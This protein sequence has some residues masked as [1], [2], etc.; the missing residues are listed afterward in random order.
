MALGRLH[1]G[2]GYRRPSAIDPRAAN[3]AAR[4]HA[5][6]SRRALAEADAALGAALEARSRSIEARS[7]QAARM[8][9]ID[10]TSR[11]VEADLG[12]AERQAA[13]A[14]AELGQ[15]NAHDDQAAVA[16]LAGSLSDNRTVLGVKQ[17]GLEALK[18][19]AA[20]RAARHDALAT[21]QTAWQSRIATARDHLES[22][23]TRR[24][25][26]ERELVGV[27]DRPAAICDERA[28]LFERVTLA[29]VTRDRAADALAVAETDLAARERAD[30]TAQAALASARE[31][32]LRAESKAAQAAQ[33][34]GAVVARVRDKLDCRPEAVAAIA[35]IKPGAEP[36]DLD[37]LRTRFERLRR[38]RDTMGPVNLRAEAEA[39]EVEEQFET[40]QT[41]RTD[42]QAAIARLRQGISNLNREGRQ[43]LLDA[44]EQVNAHF[45]R[46]FE[47]LFGGGRG[48]LALTDSDDP[49]EAGLEIMASPRGKRLQVV[50]LLSG[51]EQA[52][53]ATALLFGVFLTNPAPICVLDEVDAPLDDANVERF[54]A[55]VRDIARDTATRFA[56]V[57]HHPLTMSRMD[58]LFG[59]TMAEPG[60]S[61]MVSVDLSRA[62]DLQAAE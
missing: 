42:L 27:K 19:E 32:Q 33:Q 31:D 28:A 55:L 47:R 14:A 37:G 5:E 57:T 46:L 17:E 8:T 52:L 41:E 45:S 58:R 62:V 11:R 49:L 60:L 25:Q 2:C 53:T 39:E 61:R 48:H 59:V 4:S 56:I 22:L 26:A 50:S 21:E 36:S 38:E 18:R 43:R 54:C 16:T 40:L 9:A 29:E 12:E 6:Q 3:N 35:E 23:A 10:D 20:V 15:L 13:A 24:E 30:K 51:G 34:E 7:G 1:G 44:F